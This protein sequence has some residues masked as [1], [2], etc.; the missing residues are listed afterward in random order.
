MTTI[1]Y[2]NAHLVDVLDCNGGTAYCWVDN[3]TGAVLREF[4]ETDLEITSDYVEL[5][6]AG[7]ETVVGAWVDETGK[8]WEVVDETT[9][10][11]ESELAL[12]ED[13]AFAF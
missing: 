6:D 7:R 13:F 10:E 1:D 12:D 3:E 5:W 4:D 2:N 9:R 8:I 11:A